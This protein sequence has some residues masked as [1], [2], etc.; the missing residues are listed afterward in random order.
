MNYQENDRKDKQEMNER[1]CD[2]EN[3]KRSNP[4]EEQDNREGKEY[5]FQFRKC[6]IRWILAQ[7]PA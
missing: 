2:M 1:R 5:K 4:S 3:D 6:S 7:Q